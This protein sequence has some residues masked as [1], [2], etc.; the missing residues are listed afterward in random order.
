MTRQL[1]PDEVRVLTLLGAEYFIEW[2]ELRRGSSFFMPTT[3]TPAQVEKA[4]A[5]AR[6]YFNYTFEIRAR[7]EFGRYGARIWRTH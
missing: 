6:A 3:A 7:C 1:I 4:L 5:P 2:E